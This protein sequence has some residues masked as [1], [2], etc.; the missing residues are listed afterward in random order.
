MHPRVETGLHKSPQGMFNLR[1][2]QRVD[3]GVRG[4]AQH[5]VEHCGHPASLGAVAGG[6]TDVGTEHCRAVHRG[7][8]EVGGAGGEGPP[9]AGSRAHAQ[10][11]GN[12]SAVG[13]QSEQEV[14]GSIEGI[15]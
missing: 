12:D 10:D 1:V 4:G 8:Q 13:S 15:G 2:P 3:D 9:P 7:H 14:D 6:R 11:A 5:R